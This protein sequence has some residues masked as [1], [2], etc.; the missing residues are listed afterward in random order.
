M[1]GKGQSSRNVPLLRLV[2]PRLPRCPEHISSFACSDKTRGDEKMVRQ[3]VEVSDQEGIHRLRLVERNSGALGT[4]DDRAGEVKRGDAGRAAGENEAGQRLQHR[5]HRVDLRFQPLDL[6][7]YDP[8]RALHF[9][10][11]RGVGAEVEQ[12]VLDL[13]QAQ[14]DGLVVKRGYGDTD[15][16]IGLIDLTDRRH[17]QARL[18]DAATVNEAGRAAVPCPSVDLVELDQAYRPEEPATT[19]IRMTMTIAIAW[20]STRLRIQSCC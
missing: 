1:S 20:N 7:A 13:E 8:K 6:A 2:A 11:R 10:R 12:V 3:A 5:V 9:A 18:A 14:F 4:A 15:R 17:A 19:R 16:R